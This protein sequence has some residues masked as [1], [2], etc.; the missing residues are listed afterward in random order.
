MASLADLLGWMD[1]KRRVVGRNLSD[2]INDPANALEKTADNTLQTVK[3]LPNDP[4]NFLGVGTFIGKGAKTWDAVSMG[5]AQQMA[6]QG[7]DPRAIWKET[8]TWQGPDGH[9]RQEIPDNAARFNTSS[10]GETP[11]TRGYGDMNVGPAFG[12]KNAVL[13]HPGLADAYDA[14]EIAPRTYVRDSMTML[15]NERGAFNNGEM[16]LFA[17]ASVAQ[18]KETSLHEIQHAIQAKEGWARGGNPREFD[19]GPMFDPKAQDL[20]LDLSK[21]LTG[22]PFAAPK[23]LSD[24][25]RF[26]EPSELADIADKYGFRNIKEAIDFLRKEDFK[27]TPHG[28]YQRLA[29]EAE[30]RATQARMNMDAAQRRATFPADSYDVPIDQLIIKDGNGM[31]SLKDLIPK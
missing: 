12:R 19:S 3:E 27:R 14:G 16:T 24:S 28:Q 21:S 11:L 6:Q 25:I 5:K 20:R 15:N 22:G 7:A 2:L 17:P 13:E 29:G 10:A 9:W 23:E 8:G 18:A 4:V 30:A 1:N 31:R 26:G